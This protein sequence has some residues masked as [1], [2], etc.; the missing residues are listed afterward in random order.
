MA[1]NPASLIT[2]PSAAADAG[3]R[4]LA[5]VASMATIAV[6]ALGLWSSPLAALAALPLPGALAPAVTWVPE[7][8]TW[9]AA[10]QHLTSAVGLVMLLLGISVAAH[11]PAFALP[12]DS[13]AGSTAALGS[14]VLAQVDQ[15]TH[16][17]V[18]VAVYG[19]VVFVVRGVRGRGGETMELFGTASVHLL[20]AVLALPL[21]LIGFVIGSRPALKPTADN[22]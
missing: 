8:T 7:A 11:K 19:A 2:A 14:A 6:L 22:A 12:A 10:H 18:T 20:G 5:S 17:G 1:L 21:A 3:Y 4:A 13:R 15:L 16:A 9:T